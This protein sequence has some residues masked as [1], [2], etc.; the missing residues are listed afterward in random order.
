MSS[1][2]L[3]LCVSLLVMAATTVLGIW[4]IRRDAGLPFALAVG[5]GV[6]SIIGA[7]LGGGVVINHKICDEHGTTLNL[8]TE[9]RTFGGC[10]VEHEGKLIP[11][12]RW[13]INTGN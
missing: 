6:V 8:E 3:I 11:Y 10:Y 2:W 13:I 7:L 1:G 12:E 4:A 9:F 5:V